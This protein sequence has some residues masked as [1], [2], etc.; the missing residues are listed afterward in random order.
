MVWGT[1]KANIKLTGEIFVLK[2][3]GGRVDVIFVVCVGGER[4][5]VEEIKIININIKK[6]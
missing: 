6:I 3:G 5:Q 2:T 1:R 4:G